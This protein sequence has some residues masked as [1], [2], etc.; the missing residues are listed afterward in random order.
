MM[1]FAASFTF[2]QE[3]SKST[4]A[5]TKTTTTTAAKKPAGNMAAF[6][7]DK[8]THEFGTLEQGKP[9]TATFTFTNTGKAPLLL[10]Q[11]QGSCG[12]TATDYTK[13]AVAPGKT[14]YIKATYNAA[15]AGPFHKT[16]T[17]TANTEGGPVTLV[18]K[19]EVKAKEGGAQ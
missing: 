17:V 3:A 15:N 2:A 11:V 5:S 16:V 1:L 19:G 12:C 7:W 8:T 14:G 9:T 6:K 18:I 10:T 13:E 4:T